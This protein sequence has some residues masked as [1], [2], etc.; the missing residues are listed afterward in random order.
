MRR[1][2]LLL[3]HH[4]TRRRLPRGEKKRNLTVVTYIY[5]LQSVVYHRTLIMKCTDNGFTFYIQIYWH[6]QAKRIQ[7]VTQFTH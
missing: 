5:T 7:S 4:E 3:N 2:I 6:R 1:F